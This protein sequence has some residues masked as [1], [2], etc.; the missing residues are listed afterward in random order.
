MDQNAETEFL[1]SEIKAYFDT[2]IQYA[3]EHI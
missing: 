1:E 2:K 3:K